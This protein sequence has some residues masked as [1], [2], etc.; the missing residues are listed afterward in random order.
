M[1][2]GWGGVATRDTEAYIY[3]YASIVIP[4][5]PYFLMFS[6]YFAH[7]LYRST[8]WSFSVFT[9]VFSPKGVQLHDG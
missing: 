9:T 5:F 8:S 7:F 4:L 3:I 2:G 6:S 1:G